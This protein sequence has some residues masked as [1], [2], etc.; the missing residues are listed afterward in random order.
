MRLNKKE[1]TVPIGHADSYLHLPEEKPVQQPAQR[2]QATLARHEPGENA[3]PLAHGRQMPVPEV[4]LGPALK[5]KKK[6]KE[7]EEEEEEEKGKG[8]ENEMK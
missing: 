2:W 6:K 7:E 1:T 3:G 5:E 4:K 8:K